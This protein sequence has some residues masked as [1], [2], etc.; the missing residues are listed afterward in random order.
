MFY[1]KS[2]KPCSQGLLEEGVPSAK[3]K[4]FLPVITSPAKSPFALDSHEVFPHHIH[5]HP[6]MVNI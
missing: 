6:V 2:P 4:K 5:E 3:K 1:K